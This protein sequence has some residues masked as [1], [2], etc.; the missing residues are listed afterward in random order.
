[1]R[2]ATSQSAADVPAWIGQEKPNQS[3]PPEV[4]PRVTRFGLRPRRGVL[5]VAIGV[6]LGLLV[7]VAG[8]LLARPA[9]NWRLCPEAVECRR[10]TG[11]T[12][13]HGDTRSGERHTSNRAPHLG[14]AADLDTPLPQPATPTVRLVPTVPAVP[15]AG[16]PLIDVRFAS[17]PKPG[18]LDNPPYVAWSD[19]AYRFQARQPTHFVAV[20]APIDR[21]LGDVAV[22]AT[23]RKT[24]G[25]PGG[26]YGLVVRDQSPDPLDGV[27]QD[28]SF[29]VMEAGDQGD[30]GVWRRDG[31][32]WVDL[33][34]WAHSDSVR[35]GGSPND[36]AV[37]AIG[38]RLTFM[39][40]ESQVASVQDDTLVTGGVGV[41]VGGDYNEVALDRFVVQVPD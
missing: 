34:P 33:V 13:A 26:G 21:P 32:H 22:S 14:P 7:L 25:P 1:M 24:G 38:D 36:L 16:Q 5:L 29:Y 9:L 18:W 39:V 8:V 17:G 35:P 15:A 27:N 12:P 2:M 28:A 37:R 4:E 20:G 41:F 6:A 19:G 3:A 23:F 11:R 30:I 31:D 10:P 40:N